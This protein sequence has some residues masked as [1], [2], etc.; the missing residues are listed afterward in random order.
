MCKLSWIG[1]ARAK[2]CISYVFNT[3]WLGFQSNINTYHT[4]EIL[5]SSYG[6]CKCAEKYWTEL[7]AE[8]FVTKS[9]IIVERLNWVF[10]RR[11]M[12]PLNGSWLMIGGIYSLMSVRKSGVK[13]P[14]IGCLQCWISRTNTPE[15]IPANQESRSLGV[16]A[17]GSLTCR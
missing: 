14:L 12:K 2:S 10:V 6:S 3:M 1:L 9:A 17:L 4:S 5:Y 7:R 8:F 16:R 13:L 15:N 11:W